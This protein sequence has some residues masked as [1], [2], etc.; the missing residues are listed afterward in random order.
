MLYVQK[1]LI[2]IYHI[3]FRHPIGSRCYIPHA[4]Y[5]TKR[6][7]FKHNY[8]NAK[9][10]VFII[11]AKSGGMRG[12][13]YRTTTAARALRRQ[14]IEIFLLNI[15]NRKIKNYQNIVSRPSRLHYFHVRKYNDLKG[16]SRLIRKKG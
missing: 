16:L 4:L 5:L 9:Q 13:S 11:T 10:L 12:D 14:G 1:Q 8:E 6:R 2:I 15:G 7:V 3:T